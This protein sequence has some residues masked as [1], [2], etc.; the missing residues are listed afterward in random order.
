MVQKD[1]IH[2]LSNQPYPL[3]FANLF[4]FWIIWER[5]LYRATYNSIR[6]INLEHDLL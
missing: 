5:S 4:I 6:M 3:V 2:I 1:K